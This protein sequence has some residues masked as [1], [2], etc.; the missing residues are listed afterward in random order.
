VTVSRER[1]LGFFWGAAA[2]ALLLLATVAPVVAP[3]LPPCFFHQ[4]TGLPCPTCGGTRAT[5]A[6]L[7][8]DVPG[9]LHANPLAAVALVVLVGGG[10]VAGAIAVVGRGL[11]E[12]ERIPGWARAAVVLVLAANWLWLIVDGR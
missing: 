11:R 8:G 10:L 12:P 7:S 5:L 2:L 1:Q 9:A 3:G 6:L 4:V